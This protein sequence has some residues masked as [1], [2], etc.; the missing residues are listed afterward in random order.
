MRWTAETYQAHFAAGIDRLKEDGRYR[1]FATLERLKGEFP[2]AL[3]HEPNGATKKVVVWCSNDYLGL[4]QH[5]DIIAAMREALGKW[6]AGSGG[7]RNISGTSWVHVELEK[8]LAQ[9][10]GKEAA[11]LFNSGYTANEGALGA[12]V[13]LLPG[14]I[15]FSD[16]KNHASM[17]AGITRHRPEKF[18]FAHNDLT[19]LEA[20]LAAA[21]AALPKLIAC[22][23]VYS[24]DGTIAPLREIATLAKKYGALTYLDEVHAVGLYGP[25]GAG[26]AERDGMAG[27]FDVIEGT[28]GKAFGVAGGYVAGSTALIDAIR[29][30]APGFIFSTSLPPAIA[31]GALAS[32]GIIRGAHDLRARQ[33]RQARQLRE[34]LVAAGLP[35]LPSASHIVP[36]MIGGARCCKAVADWLYE[37]A[38]IYVQPINFPTVAVGEERLRL[39]PSPLHSDAMIDDLV[40]ALDHLWTQQHLPRRMA[41]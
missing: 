1:T 10:H 18:V 15:V 36:L 31:A 17:I 4:G 12:L 9:W 22:E 14:C 26:I 37:H 7:T 32:L 27:G 16:A 30:H 25:S 20:K 29:S 40:A 8:A 21:D 34:K 28:F 13:K 2:H 33:Q 3:M 35:V 6:G 38:A 11:L 23:S 24:M 41:A 39:T 5:P 19:D